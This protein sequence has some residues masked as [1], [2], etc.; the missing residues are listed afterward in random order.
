MFLIFHIVY[1]EICPFRTQVTSQP[2]PI[3]LGTGKNM[4]YIYIVNVDSFINCMSLLNSPVSATILSLAKE[5]GDKDRYIS[6]FL[7]CVFI[8]FVFSSFFPFLVSAIRKRMEKDVDEVGKIARGVKAKL[9]AINRDVFDLF[10][11]F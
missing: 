5:K 6:P 11:C 4:L 10:T 1:H 7:T 8:F 2:L 9:E 3:A